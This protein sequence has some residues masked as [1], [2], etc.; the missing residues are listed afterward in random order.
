MTAPVMHDLVLRNGRVVDPGRAIDR[1][2]DIGFRGGKV[3]ALGDVQGP[4]RETVDVSGYIVTPGLIDLHTHVY[5][6][7]N[8]LGVDPSDYARKSGATTVVD[9]G[10][11]GAGNFRGFKHHV[12]DAAEIRV[13]AFLNI[14]FAGIFATGRNIS[15]GESSN[16]DL[17]DPALCVSIIEEFPETIVGVKVRIG[18][19][20]SGGSGLSALSIALEA[21]EKTARPVMV[22]LDHPPPRM[23]EAIAKLRK[24]D[25]WTHCFRGGFNVPLDGDAKIRDEL[26]QA[27]ARGVIF[28]IGHGGGSFSFDTARKMMGQGFLPDTISS[29]VHTLSEHGP[30]FNLLVTMSKLLA[31]GMPLI[32]VIRSCTE[33]PSKAINRPDLGTFAVGGIG[34]A[35][36][37]N[38]ETGDTVLMDSHGD[39]LEPSRE[40]SCV[41]RVVNGTWLDR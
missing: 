28:D 12:I 17:L 10:S 19:I 40:F 13:L 41:G 9:A 1:N 30:A 35:T 29:D 39:V 26:L 3:S 32:E 27:R 15:V 5:W 36:V 11:S 24:G 20:A 2:C 6:G 22:H 25:I 21:A 33:T 14:S 23:E 34:D 18:K 16:L 38:I 7:G 4:A 37:L 31:L 8:S